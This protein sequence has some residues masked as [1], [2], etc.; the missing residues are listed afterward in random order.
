MTHTPGRVSPL[1][2]A[3][4]SNNLA[5]KVHDCMIK[6]HSSKNLLWASLSNRKGS[7]SNHAVEALFTTMA[8]FSSY[9]ISNTYKV[10]P[11]DRYKWSY[12]PTIGLLTG[13]LGW[14]N[15]TYIWNSQ[16]SKGVRVYISG[17]DESTRGSKW[18]RVSWKM[19][20]LQNYSVESICFFRNHFVRLIYNEYSL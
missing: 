15:L 13:S 1:M 3:F 5:G 12:N 16:T 11:Y 9:V 2:V 7:R 19:R 8:I 18:H 17:N 4:Q 6:K 10:G 20:S 14:N